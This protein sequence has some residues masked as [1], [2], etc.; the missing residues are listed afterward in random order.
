MKLTEIQFL[1]SHKVPGSLLRIKINFLSHSNQLW[2]MPGN[3]MLQTQTLQ[4]AW[5]KNKKT[6]PHT[7][8]PKE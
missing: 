2:E 3:L 6:L 4:P 8:T 7:V 5:P 1:V